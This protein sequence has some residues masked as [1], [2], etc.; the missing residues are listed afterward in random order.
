MNPNLKGKEG[1]VQQKL[2]K[3]TFEE[4]RVFSKLDIG[5]FVKL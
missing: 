2:E 1:K 3:M 4:A 5:R